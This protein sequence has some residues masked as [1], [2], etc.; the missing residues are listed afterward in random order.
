MKRITFV[1]LLLTAMN[2]RAGGFRDSTDGKFDLS[3]W[4]VTRKGALPVATLITEPAVGYG[5]GVGVLFFHQSIQE[6]V[7]RSGG[8]MAPPSITA[9]ILAGTENGTRVGAAGH[10]GSWKGD[11]I[12]YLGGAALLAPNLDYYGEGGNGPPISYELEGWGFVQELNFRIAD[13]DIFAGGRY[14][15]GDVSGRFDPGES[16]L[17]VNDREVTIG[18]LSANLNW[19]SRDNV[20]TPTHGANIMLRATKYAEAFGSGRDFE[21]IDAYAQLY[22]MPHERLITGLRLD[23]RGAGGDTP[24]YL[25]PYLQMRGLPALRYSDDVAALIEGELRWNVHGRWSLVGFGGTGR[26]GDNFSD[27]GS[28][29]SVRTLGGGFRYLLART[30]GLHAGLDVG[31]GPDDKAL[32]IQVGNAWR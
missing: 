20:L 2:A 13:T 1:V 24:F 22:A 32:Y 30:L 12:R 19:D 8:K 28:A 26:V 7:S 10:F 29:D 18:G 21:T 9:A 31:F 11:R 25:L 14:I 23:A 3:D 27:L 15:Y 6:S 5:L 16:G 17:P 4:L